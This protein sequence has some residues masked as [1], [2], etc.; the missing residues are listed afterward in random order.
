M[1]ITNLREEDLEML[2]ELLQKNL[3]VGHT[4]KMKKLPINREVKHTYH[5]ML[6]GAEEVQYIEACTPCF[7]MTEYNFNIRTCSKCPE[8]LMPLSKEDIIQELLD[9][10]QEI[11]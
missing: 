6:C 10:I 9:Y 2:K 3:S 5:C 1:D 4:T 7:D 8:A 11:K